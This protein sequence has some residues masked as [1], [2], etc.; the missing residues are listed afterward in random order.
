MSKNL[1]PEHLRCGAGVSCPSIHRLDDGRLLIVG[2]YLSDREILVDFDIQVGRDET[3]IVISPDLLADYVAEKVH[4]CQADSTAACAPVSPSALHPGNGVEAVASVFHKDQLVIW[5]D[6]LLSDLD[7]A[8]HLKDPED[9][10]DKVSMHNIVERFLLTSVGDR[11]IDAFPDTTPSAWR[12]ISTA[13]KDG[14]RILGYGLVGFETEKKG[15]ATVKWCPTYSEWNCD[16]NEATEYGYESCELTHWQ[17]LPLP[18]QVRGS[19]EEAQSADE[20]SAADQPASLT[21][22]ITS[23][24]SQLE[25][26]KEALEEISAGSLSPRMS[27]EIASGALMAT[28]KAHSASVAQETADL[29]QGEAHFSDPKPLG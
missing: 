26:L 6:E 5:A 12:P 14:T 8:G 13:P 19:D 15:V 29:P 2:E 20:V 11:V 23:L 25:T 4:G 10:D 1:T 17:P 24:R 28:Q 21:Q 7:A 9:Y 3:A 22:E 18:P 27:G 16:P